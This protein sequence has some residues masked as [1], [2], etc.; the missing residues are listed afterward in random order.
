MD[1]RCISRGQFNLIS[2]D[3]WRSADLDTLNSIHPVS[4]RF[5]IP[6]LLKV[7]QDRQLVGKHTQAEICSELHVWRSNSQ[8]PRI[9]TLIMYLPKHW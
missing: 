9:T 6:E 3:E 4:P 8:Y 5:P 7:G 1:G 2:G